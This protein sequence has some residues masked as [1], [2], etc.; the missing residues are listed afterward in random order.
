MQAYAP[1]A[2]RF[3]E[4]LTIGPSHWH[5]L[6]NETIWNC[7]SRRIAAIIA[8]TCGK[9]DRARPIV[10][11]KSKQLR[12]WI[13]RETRTKNMCCAC[14]TLLTLMVILPNVCV[15]THDF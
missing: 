5:Y 1:R 10:E 9:T 13:F 15:R 6:A 14:R 4:L 3:I 12:S 7:L 11:R 2:F 8:V